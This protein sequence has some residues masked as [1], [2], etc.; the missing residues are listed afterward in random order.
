MTGYA[1]QCRARAIRYVCDPGQSLTA[2]QGPALRE[3]IEGSYMLVT[4]DYELELVMKMTGF[5]REA[6]LER[7]TVIVTTLGENGSVVV[8]R[9]G[10]IAVPAVQVKGLVD[11]TGAGDAYRAGLLKG[12]VSG[13]DLETAA[14]MGAVAAAYAVEQYGTQEHTYL[15]EEFLERYRANFGAL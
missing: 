12:L 1:K 13:K 11:P 10:E 4:N 9:D 6:L 8:T 2:W 14:R 3:W 7:T 15:Y 5:D